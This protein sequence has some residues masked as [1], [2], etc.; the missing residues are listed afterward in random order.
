MSI[1]LV[2]NLKLDTRCFIT[3]QKC[4]IFGDLLES[5][6][7]LEFGERKTFSIKGLRTLSWS[8]QSG[9]KV[10]STNFI[11]GLHACDYILVDK[12]DVGI[13][14]VKFQKSNV[15]NLSSIYPLCSTGQPNATISE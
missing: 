5:S 12:I 15:L 14:N 3:I 11:F 8:G 1:G 10:M 4:H 6:R 2:S 9:Y 7:R 13:L